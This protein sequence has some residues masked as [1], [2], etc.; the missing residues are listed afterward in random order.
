MRMRVCMYMCM[1][2]CLCTYDDEDDGEGGVVW[3]RYALYIRCYWLQK[4]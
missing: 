4:K 1:Y 3:L 2:M